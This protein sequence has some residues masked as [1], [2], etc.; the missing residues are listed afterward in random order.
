[1]NK[2]IIGLISFAVTTLS[3]GDLLLDETFSYADGSLTNVSGGSWVRFS[4]TDNPSTPF[5]SSGAIT[6]TRSD[7]DDVARQFSGSQY[8]SG[9]LYYKFTLNM[10]DTPAASA[11]GYYLAGLG[12]GTSTF[13]DRLY[14]TTDGTTSGD[15]QIGVGNNSMGVR[16]GA[17][18]SLNTTYTIVVMADL[19]NDVTQLW[20]DPTSELSTF[21]NVTDADTYAVD[22][23]QF[24]QATGIGINT[25]DNLRVGTTFTDVVPEPAVLSMVGLG[26]LLMLFVRRFYGK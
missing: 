16:W 1:M 5:V 6:V 15:Y 2:L 10:S 11:D 19:D 21:V 25:I 22:S 23:I 8:L 20:I 17:D 9:K 14:V 4:G 24:R 26:V 7:A 13:R 3:Y 12:Q 18:L